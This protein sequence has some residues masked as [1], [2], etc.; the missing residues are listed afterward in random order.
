MNT[1][2]VKGLRPFFRLIVAE[3]GATGQVGL[4]VKNDYVESE[5]A[6]VHI[7]K[8]L[9]GRE[10]VVRVRRGG[11][12]PIKPIEVYVTVTSGDVEINIAPYVVLDL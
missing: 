12:N 3:W 11:R 9:L 4:V 8:G 5:Q 2:T 10:L 6:V 1:L 7:P